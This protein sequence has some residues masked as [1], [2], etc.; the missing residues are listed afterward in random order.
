MGFKHA[1]LNNYPIYAKVMQLYSIMHF[2][3]LVLRRG[4]ILL[5]FALFKYPFTIY[6]PYKDGAVDRAAG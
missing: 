6:I 2:F 1:V 3:F 4:F 5:G